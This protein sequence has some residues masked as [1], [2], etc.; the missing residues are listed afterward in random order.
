M[1]EHH[2]ESKQEQHKAV[3]HQ[4]IMNRGDDAAHDAGQTYDRYARHAALDLAEHILVTQPYVQEEAYG[5]RYDGYNKYLTEHT[6]CI[7]IHP[8]TGKHEHQQRSEHGSQQG[9]YAGHAHGV[10]DIGLTQE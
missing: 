8:L 9:R 10:S 4:R 3:L 7:H 2:S 5:N 1:A 6:P